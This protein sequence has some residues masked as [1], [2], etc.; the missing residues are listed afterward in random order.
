VG[1]GERDSEW[2]EKDR[3]V[4]QVLHC[5]PEPAAGLA[6]R[7]L[8]REAVAALLAAPQQAVARRVAGVG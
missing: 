7:N 8:T 1:S 2:Q 3:S 4:H 5:G 6:A